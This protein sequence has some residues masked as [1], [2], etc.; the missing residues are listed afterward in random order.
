MWTPSMSDCNL[1]ELIPDLVNA[2][3][4]SVLPNLELFLKLWVWYSP[5]PIYEEWD[6]TIFGFRPNL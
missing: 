2:P 3:I 6:R 1:S 5:G 4:N